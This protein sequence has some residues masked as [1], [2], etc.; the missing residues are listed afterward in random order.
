MKV[1]VVTL[2]ME[3]EKTHEVLVFYKTTFQTLV[4]NLKEKLDKTVVLIGYIKG[5]GFFASN[6]VSAKFEMTNAIGRT[7]HRWDLATIRI[8]VNLT[9]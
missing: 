7:F 2:T 6:V 4:D 9:D 1:D 8:V 3:L 5:F